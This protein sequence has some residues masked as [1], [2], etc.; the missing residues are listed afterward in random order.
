M[1]A[2]LPDFVIRGDLALVNGFQKPV[3]LMAGTSPKAANQVNDILVV[4][5]LSFEL[6]NKLSLGQTAAEKPKKSPRQSIDTFFAETAPPQAHLVYTTN[7][8][9]IRAGDHGK[10]RNISRYG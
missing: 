3:M 6:I 5:T 9:G 1:H 7:L 2:A 8:G 10:R 4:I